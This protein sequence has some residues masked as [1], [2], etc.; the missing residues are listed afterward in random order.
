[1]WY[2]ETGAIPISHVISIRRL[3]YLQTILKKSN[4][5]IVKKVYLAQKRNPCNGDW[6]KLFDSDK[7]KYNMTISDEEIEAMTEHDYKSL[8]KQRVK[9]KS[10]EELS[11]IQNEHSKVKHINFKNINKPQDYLTSKVFKNK[12]SM[13]LFKMHCESVRGIKNNFHKLY[14]GNTFCPFQCQNECDTQPHILRCQKLIEHLGI[15]HKNN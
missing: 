15:D 12:T 1:M 4:N 2:L 14:N 11:I 3:V 13:L 6:I 5:K 9:E 10:F 8:V 7:E